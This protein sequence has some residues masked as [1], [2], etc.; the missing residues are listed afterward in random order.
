MDGVTI[1]NV[2]VLS[3]IDNPVVLVKGTLETRQEYPN[4]GHY[5]SNVSINDFYLYDK[6]INKDNCNYQTN[7]YTDNINFTSSGNPITGA[8]YTPRDVSAYGNN[9]IF[10]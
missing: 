3:G 6:V 1:S 5:V 10:K 4:T 7:E 8:S 2:R 9:I